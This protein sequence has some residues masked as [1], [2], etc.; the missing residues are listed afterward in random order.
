MDIGG[1]VSIASSSIGLTGKKH[2]SRGTI[3]RLAYVAHLVCL[4]RHAYHAHLLHLRCERQVNS[5]RG[6]RLCLSNSDEMQLYS[7]IFEHCS[8]MMSTKREAAP[9]KLL[10]IIEFRTAPWIT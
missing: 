5:S 9:P 4:V 2:E 10:R 3:L 7:R 6:E 1:T 8:F